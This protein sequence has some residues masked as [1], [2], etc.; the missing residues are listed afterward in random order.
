ML[1]LIR[2]A[3][4]PL[5]DVRQIMKWVGEKEKKRKKGKERSGKREGGRQQLFS[6]TYPRINRRNV[7]R[8]IHAPVSV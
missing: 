2:E 1:L 6:N 4:S 3:N 8:I 7:T 5:K